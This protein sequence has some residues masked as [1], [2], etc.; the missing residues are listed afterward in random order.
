M[1]KKS[2]FFTSLKDEF[3]WWRIFILFVFLVLS[4]WYLYWSFGVFASQLKE[5]NFNAVSLTLW[6]GLNILAVVALIFILL[7]L[8]GMF[9]VVFELYREYRNKQSKT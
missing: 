4:G 7:L 5:C 8:V 1:K 6:G 9:I 2:N 3:D